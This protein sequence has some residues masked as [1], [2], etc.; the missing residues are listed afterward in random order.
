[1]RDLFS[2]ASTLG[3]VL[4]ET[5]GV[6][7][8]VLGTDG[9]DVR[10]TVGSFLDSAA[11]ASTAAVLIKEMSAIGELLGLGPLGVASLRATTASHVFALQ[12]GALLAVEL[13]PKR[14]IGELETKLLTQT[15][16]P[17]ALADA[18]LVNRVPTA[19]FPPR[20][21]EPSTPPSIA[22]PGASP[23]ALADAP[24]VAPA[25]GPAG[26]GAGPVVP[27]AVPTAP[28]VPAPA[29]APAP[30]QVSPGVPIGRTRHHDVTRPPPM[31][32]VR[33]GRVTRPPSPSPS[34]AASTSSN[35]RRYPGVPA[36]VKSVGS[37]PVF[38]GDLEEFCLPDL[39]EFLRNSHRTGLLV[40]TTAAGVGTI[41]LSRGM[42]IGAESPNALDLREHLLACAELAPEQRREIT[43]LP[44]ECFGDDVIDGVLVSRDLVARDEIEQARVARIY[45][46]FREMMT[47][48]VGRFSFDPGVAV[49]TNPALALSAQSI[50]MH[51]Y[52]EQDEQ[53]R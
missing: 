44:A 43:E 37:G 32:P 40:C 4:G 45:S 6:V 47:W 33:P 7:G 3:S 20:S 25:G 31:R 41:Q 53:G 17:D 14:P 19:T 52:Q 15:W 50:L 27:A 2:E 23:G 26:N 29:R 34:S 35:H 13:D 42:I 28:P 16:A 24:A 10:G 12:R 1:M 48:T 8:V 18:Q 49:V 39:L 38:T 51:I 46:A 30:P 11:T 9:G 5:R 36:Q 21:R 22:S